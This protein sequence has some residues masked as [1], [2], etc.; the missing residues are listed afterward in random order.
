MAKNFVQG[1]YIPKNPEKYVGDLNKIVYRSSYELQMHQFLDNNT[2]VVEWSSEEIV[3]PY[4]YVLDHKIHRYFPDYYV[5]Y[6]NKSGE[7]IKEILEVKPL[8]QTK[9]PRK[10]SKHALYEQATYIK[11]VCK[12]K[13]AQ[14]WCEERGYKF[15]ILSE[16]SI[17]S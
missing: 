3:I 17:F 7:I 16:R 10:N 1:R 2:K 6:I 12:W 13:A 11:N 5:A 4:L 15:R 14:R 8:S 9:P